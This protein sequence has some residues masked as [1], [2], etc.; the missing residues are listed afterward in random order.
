MTTASSS[1]PFGLTAL[2]VSSA[3]ALSSCGDG[4]HEAASDKTEAAALH[5]QITATHP[6]DNTSFTQ[7]LAT[8][9]DSLIAGT[10]M[11]GQSRIYRTTVDGQQSDNHDL[12]PQL[13]G[14]GLAVHGDTVWQLTW[15]E[16][17]AIKRDLATLRETGSETYDGEGWGLCS[18]GERLVMSDGS[19]RLTFRD[20]DTFSEIGGVD[21]TL[22]GAATDE[23]NELDCAADGSVWANV[24]Q[25]NDIYRIDPISGEVTDVADTSGI[26]PAADRPGSDVLNGIA[27]VPGTDPA[28]RRFY[29]TGKYWDELYEVQFRS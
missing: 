17:T 2:I 13:F 28:E 1:H 26:F 9:G 22:N 23:L 7:G 3:L 18:D 5:T 20:P 21:V 27:S 25:S 10:G 8:D 14:E 24:W 12:A 6:W 16:H 29:V 4:G 19:G 15:K 11:Y